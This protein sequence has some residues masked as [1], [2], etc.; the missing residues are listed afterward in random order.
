VRSTGVAVHLIQSERYAEKQTAKARGDRSYEDY[1]HDTIVGTSDTVVERL[2]RLVE[3]G[4]DY[5]SSRF[6]V[7]PTIRSLC[8]S[9]RRRSCHASGRERSTRWHPSTNRCSHAGAA[10]LRRPDADVLRHRGCAT[11]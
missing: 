8:G 4:A 3:A 5:L 9:L 2:Q 1:A 6:R 11:L 7:S 10:I